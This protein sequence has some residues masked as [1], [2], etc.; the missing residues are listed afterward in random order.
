MSERLRLPR[1][2]VWL[3]HR[4]TPKAA[5]DAALGDILEVLEERIAVGRTPRWPALWLRLQIG[6]AIGSALR[7]ATPRA[8]R[9]WGHT[10]RDAIRGTR[11]RPAQTLF[12]VFVL[13]IGMSAATVTFSVVDATVLRPLP[14]EDGDRIVTITGRRP[15]GVLGLSPE[16]FWLIHDHVRGLDSIAPVLQWSGADVTVDGVTE[17]LVVLHTT[18]GLFRVLRLDAFI[19]SVWTSDH[20]ASDPK[21]AVI[22]HTFWHRRFGGDPGAVGQ[23]VRVG[24][25]DYRII[26][27]LEP[28]VTYPSLLESGADVWVPD[29]PVRA[30][31]PGRL[32]RV[33]PLARL[34]PGTSIEQLV[35][36]IESLL[37]PLVSAN[38]TAYGSW[39]LEVRRWRDTLSES[40]RPWMLLALGSVCLVLLIACANAANVMLT[41]SW[42]R[43]GELAVRASLGA[44][45]RQL[46]ATL[47]I[48]SVTL[49][50]AA[51]A[52]AML[53]AWWGIDAARSALPVRPFG[54]DAIS[55]DARV[56]TAGILAALATGIV[57]GVVP[58][59][60]ASR[61]SV[62]TLLKDG[63]ATTTT[64]RRGWRSVFLT[65]Q[66]ASVAA[67]LVIATLFIGSFVRVMTADLGLDRSNLI[68][69]STLTGNGPRVTEFHDRLRAIPGVRRVAAVGL[70]TPPLVGPAFGGAYHDMKVYRLETGAGAPEVMVR[71][72]AVSTE[73]FEVV[74]TP[75]RRGS[76]WPA[77]GVTEASPVPIVID[78]LTARQLFGEESPVG[79][80][81][82]ARDPDRVFTV[83]G[84][85][86]Y[87]L[88]GG[89][90]RTRQSSAYYP[91][92]A[93][94]RDWVGFFIKTSGP[95][96]PVAR[97]VHQ[98][99]QSMVR[100]SQWPRVHV[101]DDAFRRL[102][103]LRRFNGLL[104][105]LFAG[106]A[107]LIGCAGVYAAMASAVSQRTREIGVRLA[108]GASAEAIRRSI[109]AESG[110]HLLVGLSIGLPAGWV[111]SRSFGSIFF[112]VAPGD[113]SIH[114][115]VAAVL[116]V[117][118]LVAAA[119]PARRAAR[120][121]P[122]VTLRAL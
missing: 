85:V 81:L 114:A 96:G 95:P 76:V 68:G 98:T 83:T 93:M 24:S 56:M 47:F 60:Q 97:E 121:D 116:V 70:S 41:R 61:V 102:T 67:L 73:Y 44:S 2:L 103:A 84:V 106:L 21:V 39:R 66:V 99:L 29:S 27:V 25:T 15:T 11:R 17:N 105:L 75:F 48:E 43:T 117:A 32:N 86:P 94:G 5:A 112:E 120:V 50:V 71:T 4:L 108:L 51:S 107:V 92:E 52:F 78:D 104:M 37:A 122:V 13:A 88:A 40:V 46:G 7:T 58:G 77:Q 119:V 55:L 34:A 79:R 59:W 23:K 12:I 20:E 14:F 69:V 57:C 19:G 22:A 82:R 72:Y 118:G 90:E 31:V 28:G 26:G 89:P 113:V 80:L 8:A 101:V 54:W 74:G 62:L 87:L 16:A 35:S 64:R 6:L 53:F 109:L 110:R 91:L 65:A 63:G 1:A 33:S 38:P 9:S 30:S 45:R 115:L 18:A 36:E 111:M 49:S 42:E 3:L 100:P 10:V